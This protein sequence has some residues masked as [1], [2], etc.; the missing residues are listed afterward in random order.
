[1]IKNWL[2]T[3]DC[4]GRV[5]GRLASI[6]KN[7]PEYNPEETAVI[8]LGDVGFNYYKTKHDWKTKHRAAKFGYTIYC[9][10]GNHE[11]R[12]MNMEDYVLG[13][14]ENVDGNV[15]YEE[16]FPNIKYFMDYVNPYKINGC[17]VLCI[18]GAYSVDKWYR[19][20]N[21]WH[22]FPQE[23]LTAEEMTIAEKEHFGKP[24]DFV[25]SH[26]APISWEPNDLFLSMI[27]QSTV[28]KSMEIWLDKFKDMI[29]WGVWLFGH[30]HADRIERPCVEQ[31]YEEVEDFNNIIARWEKYLSTG[32]LDWWLPKSP[33][34]YMG[35]EGHTY[36]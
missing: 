28:D 12:A 18:P 17:R 30:Y 29:G 8:I 34:F 9:L 36:G 3:G 6:K 33:N 32:E 11:D 25:F 35:C 10:R 15:I 4:H 24:Y 23:Q 14:D 2:I 19:L 7:M 5:E 20:Q 21:E 13:Y 16:E 22:W 31:F 1:M 27:D 26:T